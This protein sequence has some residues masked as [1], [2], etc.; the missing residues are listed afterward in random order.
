MQATRE[1]IARLHF[2]GRRLKEEVLSIFFCIRSKS[3]SEAAFLVPAFLLVCNMQRPADPDAR[4]SLAYALGVPKARPL[5]VPQPLA[6]PFLAPVMLT[7]GLGV[8][9]PASSRCPDI[10]PGD[11]ASVQEQVPRPVLPEDCMSLKRCHFGAQVSE[12]SWAFE[13]GRR[14][15]Q[16]PAQRRALRG[17]HLHVPSCFAWAR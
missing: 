5:Q 14:G 15:P 2:R 11:T 6:H 13:W 16:A 3:G 8:P 7:S 1:E 10:L 4:R 12:G 9:V 17:G